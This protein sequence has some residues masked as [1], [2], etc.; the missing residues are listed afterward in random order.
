MSL[1]PAFIKTSADLLVST[2][3]FYSNEEYWKPVIGNNPRYFVHYQDVN[4]HMFGLSK[5]CAFRNVSVERYISA[6]RYE[7]SG[8]ITQKHIAAITKKQ[9]MPRRA[10]NSMVRNA[11]DSWIGAF[12]PN[13]NVGN[14]SFITIDLQQG[15]TI[16]K[17]KKSVTP[18]DLETRLKLQ[19]E[20]GKIGE[21]IAFEYEVSRLKKLGVKNPSK[22]VLHVSKSNC[23]AGYDIFSKLGKQERYIEVKSSVSLDGCFYISRG[24]LRRLKELQEHAYI[25]LVHV[26]DVVNK[27]GTVYKEVNDPS[28]KL[29][30][31]GMIEPILYEAKFA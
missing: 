16:N 3:E 20:I 29:E 23:S 4:T 11:F 31:S 13:Y 15:V 14:A 27:K 1:H 28:A 30:Q 9:W 2:M 26:T 25:Y 19:Q 18:E 10:V 12:F 22:N 5:Y 17:G 7:T 21:E 24:E 6:Y 8:G